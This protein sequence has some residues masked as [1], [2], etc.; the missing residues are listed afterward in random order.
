[1]RRLTAIHIAV[2]VAVGLLAYSNTF[3]VPFFLDS[4]FIID[5]PIVKDIRFPVEQIKRLNLDYYSHVK[6]RYAAYLTFAFNYR[7]H[8]FEVFG[9]HV[10]NISLHL[11][12]ALLVYCLVVLTLRAP[13]MAGSV[14]FEKRSYMA[15][16]VS[17]IFVV[18]PVQTEAVNWI[19]QRVTVLSAFFYLGSLTAYARAR[20]EEERRWK[21]YVFYCLSFVS[22]VAAMKSKQNAFTLPLMAAIYEFA[23]FRGSLKPRLIRLIP[24][25]LTLG[26]VPYTYL[27]GMDFSLERATVG[28]HDPTQLDMTRWNYLFSQFRVIVTYI[29]LLFIPVN[30]PVYRAF[31]ISKS[32]FEPRVILGFSFISVLLSVGIYMLIR[33]REKSGAVLIVGFGI[34]WFFLS[35]SVES[36]LL[37]IHVV[38][39]MYRAYLPSVGVFISVTALCYIMASR[40]NI[41]RRVFQVLAFSV[42]A[43]FAVSS[44][45]R[46]EVWRSAVS[47]AKD[48]VK[49]APD[50]D[51][52]HYI[53]AKAYRS[54]GMHEKAEKEFE[55]ALVLNEK[56]TASRAQPLQGTDALRTANAVTHYRA[57]L[58]HH[59]LGDYERAIGEYQ[60]AL[61]LNPFYV[62]ARTNLAGVYAQLGG[63]DDAIKE[64]QSALRVKPDYAE[65]RR[66]LGMVYLDLGRLKESADE[67]R[68]AVR[69]SPDYAEAHNNLGEVYARMGRTKE[70]VRE[71]KEALRLRPGFP[72]AESNLRK[73]AGKH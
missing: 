10:V 4:N 15:F 59:G 37:P 40:L 63:Y 39:A 71:F 14:L 65:A 8:G 62:E 52:V 56:K 24:F 28:L 6:H 51:M 7:L 9:Y 31:E 58:S 44:Y 55:L 18:H 66:F 64:L 47:L 50:S 27:S 46:N 35:L 12:N 70:A 54:E 48:A 69:L 13:V 60:M 25:M 21:R 45:V 11:L 3:Y 17:L 34:V 61:S 5:N 73:V 36:S 20:L 19:W 38:I 23:F 68:E 32:F 57:G 67:L 2:V 42:I 43:V 29:R 22:A 30:L 49:N 72:E 1:M 16:F 53:L 33:F 26:I 41:N